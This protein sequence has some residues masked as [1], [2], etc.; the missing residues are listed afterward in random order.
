M[1]HLYVAQGVGGLF[2]IGRSSDPVARAKALQRE[3]A[4]RGDKLEKLTPC[5]SVENAYAIEYAL[6][7]WV[8]RTQIRQS[9]R[10]WFVS[11]DFDA[12][13]KQAQALTAERRKRDAYEQSPRG[14]AARRRQQARILALQ[15]EWAAAK[16]SH[17]TSRAQYKADVA[18]RRK[19]KALRVNGAMDAMAAFLIARS[20][21]LA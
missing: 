11:G 3:F 21:Q 2:K 4:A 6:Q 15:Q 18:K 10:E 14:K 5:E 20:T 16:V 13:L 8:A 19:A 17:L 9:G 1:E 7:S 12:T